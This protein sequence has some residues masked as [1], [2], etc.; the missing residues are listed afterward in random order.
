MDSVRPWDLLSDDMAD[1]AV[2][3]HRMSL[4]RDCDKYISLTKQCKECW[5]IMPLKTKI[6]A[7]NCPIGKWPSLLKED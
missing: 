4:C 6:A 3:E 5:C 1:A 2:I 7:A